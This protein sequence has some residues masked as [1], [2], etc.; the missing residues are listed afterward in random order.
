MRRFHG[1]HVPFVERGIV[2]SVMVLG[3]LIAL[4]ARTPVA[5]SM[6]I[7]ALFALFHG[8]SH[9]TE[10]PVNAVGFAY[11]AGFALATAALHACGIGLAYI[12]RPVRLPVIRW[13]GAA[14]A[15]CGLA[16]W[17]F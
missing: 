8:H 17:T 3:L 15:L 14:I 4:A 5:A 1:I 6:A 16:L 7:V 2:L 9:G 11:G 10:M 12:V 13:A